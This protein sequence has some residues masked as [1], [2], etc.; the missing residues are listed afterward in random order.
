MDSGILLSMLESENA[1]A[2]QHLVELRPQLEDAMVK[3][4]LDAKRWTELVQDPNCIELV[5]RM[6]EKSPQL[7]KAA[8]DSKMLLSLLTQERAVVAL[9]LLEVDEKGVQ[10]C[11]P[12]LFDNSRG[13]SAWEAACAEAA[14]QQDEDDEVHS[15]RAGMLLKLLKRLLADRGICKTAMLP[16]HL[17]PMMTPSN[18]RVLLMMVKAAALDDAVVDDLLGASGWTDLVQDPACV[19]LVTQMM[20]KSAKLKEKAKDSNILLS[21]LRPGRATQT[22]SMLLEKGATLDSAARQKLVAVQA[23]SSQ[24]QEL[25]VDPACM[26]VVQ[27]LVKQDESGELLEAAMSKDVFL[28]SLVA[29]KLRVVSWLLDQGALRKQFAF[30]EEACNDIVGENGNWEQLV[31]D[32][33]SLGLVQLLSSQSKRLKDAACSEPILIRCLTS[34]NAD[35]AVWLLEQDHTLLGTEAKHF[36]QQKN[37]KEQTNWDVLV[38]SQQAAKLAKRLAELASELK[39]YL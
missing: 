37:E 31:T 27:Q 15:K 14:V 34:K 19:E 1:T 30:F 9:M 11:A 7:T 22:A 3:K 39:V 36:L 2:A 25:L 28:A 6:M 33:K 35:I 5:K 8:T 17:L 12:D 24:W 32:P 29:Q 4:L 23:G 21:M 38:K 16:Q 26:Q 13:L 10:A 20:E 18:R